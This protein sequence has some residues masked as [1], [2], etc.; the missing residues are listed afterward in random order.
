MYSAALTNPLYPRAVTDV[1]NKTMI[2]VTFDMLS[3]VPAFVIFSVMSSIDAV[4]FSSDIVNGLAAV[5]T[6][7][8][9]TLSAAW[10]ALMP[11]CREEISR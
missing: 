11:F 7:L 6:P 10:K 3:N 4:M 9:V 2:V 8:R 1:L 5:A